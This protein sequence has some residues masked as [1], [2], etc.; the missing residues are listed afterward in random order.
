MRLIV[1]LLVL[2]IVGWLVHRQLAVAPAPPVELPGNGASEV[3]RVPQRPQDL[4]AF[5]QQLQ[6]FMH[7]SAAER[8]REL[9]ALER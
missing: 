5:E 8:R 4:P 2:L 1:L 3:P 7:D 6:Q 9:E